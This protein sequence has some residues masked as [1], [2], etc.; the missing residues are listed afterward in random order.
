MHQN[1]RIK[2]IEE[3]LKKNGFVT[4]K[5]LTEEL[6]YST[7]TINRD[8]N[9]M[10]KK[11]M[12]KR[13]YGGVELLKSRSVP[14]VFRYNKMRPAK[15]KI[16]KKAAEFICDGDT[17]LIDGS[18]T[19]QY[20][21][22]Y[23]TEKKNLTV[24]TNNLALASFLSEYSITVYCLGGKIAEPPSMAYS[25]ET[26]ENIYKY[27]ADKAF[28]STG[29]VTE[30]GKICIGS[31]IYTLVIKAMIEQSKQQFFLVDHEKVISSAKRYLGTLDEVTN[32]ITDFNFSEET[33]QRFI[34]TTFTEVQ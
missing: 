1:E 8:L 24:I 5:F 28:F 2:H 12:V 29:G 23:L 22:K 21:G 10:E 31:G 4:V 11:K 16:G 3:I 19:S 13:S 17:I 7:A 15:N 20:I 30:D 32:I 34:N 18:T 14:L 27:G 9:M 6:H 26:V 25:E 33:K